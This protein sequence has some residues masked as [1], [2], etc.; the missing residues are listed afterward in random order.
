MTIMVLLLHPAHAPAGVYV[1]RPVRMRDRMAARLRAQS[2]D[3]A[4]ARGIDPE[5][6]A[7]LALR[8]RA[9]TEHCRRRLLARGLERAAAARVPALA[10]QLVALAGRLSRPGP[11][12]ARGVA[13]VNLLLTDAGGPLYARRG[14]LAAAIARAE[15]DLEL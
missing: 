7:A 4:L 8:A 2:L 13:E 11:V 14:D 9:L 12:A 15:H 1:A 3:A 6:G 10:P 5:T